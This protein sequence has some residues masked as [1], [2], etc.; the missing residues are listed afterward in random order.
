[1]F[2]G[3]VLLD[4]GITFKKLKTVHDKLHREKKEFEAFLNNPA[5]PVPVKPE[6]RKGDVVRQNFPARAEAGEEKTRWEVEWDFAKNGRVHLLRIV[7]AKFS[8][9]D[10]DGSWK[11]VTVARNLELVEAF[12]PYDDG[13]TAFLDLG[14]GRADLTVPVRE[15]WQG[16]PC[17]APPQILKWS[18]DPKLTVSREVHDDGIRWITGFSRNKA[19]RG[20]KLVLL[21]MFQAANYVYQVEY[22]FT[23][24]GRIVPK[25]GFT[26]H[27]FF[28]RGKSNNQAAKDGDVHLHVGCWRMDFDLTTDGAAGKQGGPARNDYRLISRRPGGGQ[29]QPFQVVDEPFGSDPEQGQN[30]AREGKA[31]WRPEEFTTL[32]VRSTQATNAAGRPVAYDLISTRMGSVRNLPAFGDTKAKGAAF[33]NYDFWVTRTPA[34][35]RPYHDVPALA[36]GQQPLAGQP[37][38]VYYSAPGIHV[39]RGED[40]GADGAANGRGVALTTWIEFTL[41]PRDLFDSTPLYP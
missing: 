18:G 9:K 24:D 15:A 1:M 26:A 3:T 6:V 10:R 21:S 2:A 22:D 7:S 39:P 20:E 33:A 38:T 17:V 16:P 8:F 19:Y 40:F 32:R 31:R 29:G 4:E 28:A 36:K 13:K 12:A 34:Q 5:T 37:A 30:E 27:N 41:R 35:P 11:S 25:L 14:L 23:D